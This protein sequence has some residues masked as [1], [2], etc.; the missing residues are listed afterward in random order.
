MIS[1]EKVFDNKTVFILPHLDDEFAVVPLIIEIIKKSKDSPK[2]IFCAERLDE[3]NEK[4]RMMKRR[5][6]NIKSM[7]YLGIKEKNILYINDFFEV[8]DLNLYKKSNELFEFLKRFIKENKIDQ[9]ITTNFEGGHPDHDAL[10]IIIDK[11]ARK[12]KI[13]ALFIPTYNSRPTAFVIPFSVFRPLQEQLNHFTKIK[14]HYLCWLDSIVVSMF[15]LTEFR[16]I[17]KLMPF[18]IFN[19]LFSNTI[20]ITDKINIHHVDWNDS[21]SFKR[22]KMKQN[23]ILE[24]LK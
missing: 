14:F 23:K 19:T 20:F 3:K 9:L 11:L 21:L 8:K 2:I 12:K 24:L 5:N 16:T 13:N 15:Y 6:E 1:L 22:Y 7:K 4:N 17:I 18:L 10:A